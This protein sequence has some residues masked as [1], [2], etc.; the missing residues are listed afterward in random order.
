M[1]AA[2][3]VF[4][5]L[6]TILVLTEV[7]NAKDKVQEINRQGSILGGSLMGG[8]A[9]SALVSPV[10][11]PGAPICAFVLILVGGMAGGTV[12]K[13]VN[14]LYQEELRHFQELKSNLV[15]GA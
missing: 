2:G 4:T 15:Y 6:T 7:F 11:G 1:A 13:K 8:V 12:A 10:C 14:D 9:G 5:A 3:K